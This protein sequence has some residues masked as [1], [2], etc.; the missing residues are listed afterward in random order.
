MI[1]DSYVEMMTHDLFLETSDVL[2]RDNFCEANDDN[3]I[4]IFSDSDGL[5]F[6][7]QLIILFLLHG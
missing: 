7:V 4:D 1:V 5:H 2:E 6:I 3:S